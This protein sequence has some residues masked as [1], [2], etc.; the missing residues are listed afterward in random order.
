MEVIKDFIKNNMIVI[1]KLSVCGLKPE[2]AILYLDI[3][4]YYESLSH[5]KSKMD[6]YTLTAETKNVSE[7]TVR[8]IVQLLESEV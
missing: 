3:Y 8:Q 1:R 4:C 5:L 6:R 7:W 2:T